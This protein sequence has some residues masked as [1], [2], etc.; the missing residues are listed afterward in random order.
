MPEDDDDMPDIDWNDMKYF[1]AINPDDEKPDIIED[2]DND[3]MLDIDENEKKYFQAIDLNIKKPDINEDSDNDNWLDIDENKIKYFQAIDLNLKSL[4]LYE[5]SDNDDMSDI[6]EQINKENA[7]KPLIKLDF[8]SNKTHIE[9]KNTFSQT[10]NQNDTDDFKL[11]LN[12]FSEKKSVMVENDDK[13]VFNYNDEK[14]GFNINLVEKID[15]GFPEIMVIFDKEILNRIIKL[16]QKTHP[17]NKYTVKNLGL[18]NALYK[19]SAV[20]RDLLSYLETLSDSKIPHQLVLGGKHNPYLDLKESNKLAQLIGVILC[21]G[22]IIIIPKSNYSLYLYFKKGSRR[23]EDY[24]LFLR[25][26]INSIFGKESVSLNPNFSKEENIL[27]SYKLDHISIIYEL[28]K[29]GLNPKEKKI[30]EW[31]FDKEEYKKNCLKGI[32]NSLARFNY[33]VTKNKDIYYGDL[34]ISFEKSSESLIRDIKLI[35]HSYDIETSQIYSRQNKKPDPRTGKYYNRYNLVVQKKNSINLIIENF[36]M[37]KIWDIEKIKIENYFSKYNIDL[38]SV[39]YYDEKYIVRK[40]FVYSKKLTLELINLFE[41]SGNYSDLVKNFNLEFP[42]YGFNVLGNDNIIKYIKN[43]FKE[44]EVILA[45]GHDG[46]NNWYQN[47][48]RIRYG[49]TLE[50]ITIPF[51]ILIQ[52]YRKIFQIL[53]QNFFIID[54]DYLIDLLYNYLDNSLM[55][56]SNPNSSITI[57]KFGR[58]SYM[59]HESNG[60]IIFRKY[61]LLIAKFIKRIKQTTTNKKRVS[62]YQMKREFEALFYHHQ[63]IKQIIDDLSNNFNVDLK[64]GFDADYRWHN[65]MFQWKLTNFNSIS[66]DNIKENLGLLFDKIENGDYDNDMFQIKN[67]TCS[68]FYISH[69]RSKP[70]RNTDLK[71]YIK[72]LLINKIVLTRTDSFV[73]NKLINYT[74]ESEEFYRLNYKKYYNDIFNGEDNVYHNKLQEFIMEND[75]Y[76]I[77]TEVLVW[78]EINIPNLDIDYISG[79]IDFLFYFKNCL[80]ICDYKPNNQYQRK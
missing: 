75:E 80:Y 25:N 17:N 8:P 44:P 7:Q 79:H 28:I 66:N 39:L 51:G 11:D 13:S 37:S 74:K 18:N 60:R 76:V 40:D 27:M 2:S 43:F 19:G 64:V 26:L 49:S 62:F 61:F 5:D 22:S 1:R 57:K 45:Y 36:L 24:I 56:T 78:R 52:I 15:Y 14:D 70:L 67:P 68:D 21:S 55:K 73:G 77:A 58:I 54:D 46:Y 34:S 10:S 31:I 33:S 32:V 65:L 12:I 6:D 16:I 50:S 3:D 59:I 47:N 30:P 29:F 72:P 20:S 23:E 63:Q 9:K 69:T 42:E 71:P 41:I 4:N 35:L 53:T 48:A 38:N